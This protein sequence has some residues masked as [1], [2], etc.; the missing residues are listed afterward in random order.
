M[1]FQSEV[2]S[3][4]TTELQSNTVLWLKKQKFLHP[5]S[6][7]TQMFNADTTWHMEVVNSSTVMLRKELLLQLQGPTLKMTNCDTNWQN[8]P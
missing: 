3:F 5:G 2:N 8:L 6:L 7:W 1:K 4:H